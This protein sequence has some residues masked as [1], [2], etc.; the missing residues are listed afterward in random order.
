[1]EEVKR[2]WVLGAVGV[3]L[4][5]WLHTASALPPVAG[6]VILTVSGKVGEMNSADGAAF[7][8]AMLQKLPQHSFV[9]MTP[10]DKKPIQ[11]SG[12][13]LRDVLAA[14][15]ASGKTLKASALND[16]QVTIPLDDAN[17]FDVIVAHQMNGTAIPVKTKG[18]LFIVYPYDSALELRS[19]T[20]YERS[21]WQLKSLWVD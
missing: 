21:V 12:P 9:T 14:A 5:T 3:A 8:L 1:M 15:H 13:L 17:R 16:Y 4:L 6:K 11:F 19:T 7:D 20:Y 18:P 10:W 2:R